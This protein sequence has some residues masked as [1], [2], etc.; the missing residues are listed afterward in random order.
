M[1]QMKKSEWK[2]NPIKGKKPII[3]WE[4]V[5]DLKIDVAYQRAIDSPSSQR[6]IRDI[7]CNWDWDLCSVLIV[8]D[9]GDDGLHVIVGQHR[10]AAAKLRVDVPH[11]PCVTIT[12]IGKEAEAKKFLQINTQR[13]TVTPLDRFRARL[14]VGDEEAVAINDLV[15]RAGLKVGR[16]PWTVKENEVCCVAVMTRLYRQYGAPILS[17]SLVNMAEAWP[18]E[19]MGCA[20]EMLPGLALLLYADHERIDPERLPEVLR[21]RTQ[22][23]WFVNALSSEDRDPEDVWPDEV[24]RDVILA[25]YQKVV[26]MSEPV[27]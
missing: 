8:A 3:S 26:A 14:M 9:R 16:S 25:H 6:L 5:A 1:T 15:E 21:S 13:K 19:P 11:L 10:L 2:L 4:A 23:V 20:Q 27:N 17:A 22:A 24:F 7:A 18:N 12:S